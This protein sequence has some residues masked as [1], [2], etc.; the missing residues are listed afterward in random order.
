MTSN[1]TQSTIADDL[2]PPDLVSVACEDYED[3]SETQRKSYDAKKRSYRALQQE[4][5]MA[6]MSIQKIHTTVLKSAR[7]YI[8]VNRKTSFVRDILISLVSKFK[9][10]DENLQLQIDE[11]YEKLKASHS[12]KDQI[13][14]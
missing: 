8:A 3:L 7:D 2:N 11:R 1:S 12:I 4:V 9:R 5:K 6:N 13:E 14:S 10:L